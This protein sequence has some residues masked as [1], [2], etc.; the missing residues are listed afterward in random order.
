[1][2]KN[3]KPL[4]KKEQ[5][6]LDFEKEFMRTLETTASGEALGKQ[7]ESSEE[8][9]QHSNEDNVS[10][11]N[12]RQIDKIATISV[13]KEIE[14]SKCYKHPLNLFVERNE[15]QL[16][17]LY[18]SILE[19]GVRNPIR[20][21]STDNGYAITKGWNRVLAARK[22]GLKVIPGEVETAV[23]DYDQIAKICLD[24]IGSTDYTL[25]QDYQN[26][27][28]FY[29]KMESMA[30]KDA[31]GRIIGGWLTRMVSDFGF[32]KNKA[33]KFKKI[34]DKVS[35]IIIEEFLA[36]E[37]AYTLEGLV[38]L[39]SYD[40]SV[41]TRAVRILTSLHYSI[42]ESKVNSISKLIIENI[43]ATNEEIIGILKK[44]KER[45]PWYNANKAIKL[46]K[47]NLT[48]NTINRIQEA[49]G[50]IS[51]EDLISRALNQYFEDQEQVQ[52]EIKE[53]TS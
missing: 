37:E 20:Y 30:P 49:Y 35:I 50:D 3:K 2:S 18:N 48:T 1:M 53:E 41:Q 28:N 19:Q 47:L 7:G 27:L 43:H 31:R 10:T 8:S 29:D 15:D 42:N 12:K 14:L 17:L 36:E 39:S 46:N 13:K 9:D 21:E 32:E 16:D 52:D 25:A 6:E 45:K 22:A 38:A 23:D 11:Q 5:A 26:F 4:S 34:R 51:A 24:N 33:K 40:E 44:A